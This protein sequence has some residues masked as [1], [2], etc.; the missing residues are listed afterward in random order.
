MLILQVFRLEV[1]RTLADDLVHK[2]LHVGARAIR[3]RIS[4]LGDS[5]SYHFFHDSAYGILF[6]QE[7]LAVFGLQRLFNLFI[8]RS[9]SPYTS[10]VSGKDSSC[11]GRLRSMSPRGFE[12]DEPEPRTILTSPKSGK[13][14]SL[15]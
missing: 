2:P 8:L 14:V 13:P 15:Q 12:L 9:F 7:T 1:V 5:P 10:M 3:A 11:G 6:L 4:L